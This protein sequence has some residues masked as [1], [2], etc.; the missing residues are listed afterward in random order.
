MDAVVKYLPSPLDVGVVEA[1]PLVGGEPDMSA[2]PVV[3]RPSINDPLCALAFKVR[4]CRRGD[5]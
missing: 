1:Q 4:R 2:D 3:R 5:S